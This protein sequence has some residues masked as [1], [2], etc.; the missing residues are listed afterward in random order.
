MDINSR[1]PE[2]WAIEAYPTSCSAPD[3]CQ[4]GIE[5]TR[6][7]PGEV[8]VLINFQGEWCEGLA[9]IRVTD[10]KVPVAPVLPL[11]RR[12]LCT[13]LHACSIRFPN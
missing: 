8:Y 6:P 11:T 10:I 3:V 4:Q 1:T 13:A 5:L 12:L 9:N 7:D 2:R